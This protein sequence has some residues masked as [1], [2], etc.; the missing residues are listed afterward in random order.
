[1]SN[2][3]WNAHVHIEGATAKWIGLGWGVP[4]NPGDPRC[5][6]AEITVTAPA[7]A[8]A[9]IGKVGINETVTLKTSETLS[10]GP[11]GI[12][13]EICYHVEP[14]NAYRKDCG[15]PAREFQYNIAKNAGQTGTPTGGV[16]EDGIGPI[17]QDVTVRVVVP[18]SCP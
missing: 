12:E 9:S 10:C 11:D 4:S 5:Y 15:E 16:L 13:L 3:Q 7:A 17:G 1:M 18:G 2:V 14:G 6:E 8:N